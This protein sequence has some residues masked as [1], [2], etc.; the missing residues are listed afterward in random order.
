MVTRLIRIGA[1]W[2]YEFKIMNTSDLLTGGNLYYLLQIIIIGSRLTMETQ[3][4][5]LKL[6]ISSYKNFHIYQKSNIHS[7]LVITR[8]RHKYQVVKV[9]QPILKIPIDVKKKYTQCVM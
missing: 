7:V 4:W 8:L 2:N 3:E 1:D 5:F 6:K 9:E